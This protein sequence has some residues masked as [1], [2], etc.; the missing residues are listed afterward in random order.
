MISPEAAKRSP[1]TRNAS[2]RDD[3]WQWN[4]STPHDEV[5]CMLVWSVRG[6]QAILTVWTLTCVPSVLERR[7][8]CLHASAKQTVCIWWMHM[9]NVMYNSEVNFILIRLMIM[10]CITWTA[11]PMMASSV[12]LLPWTNTCGQCISKSI[13]QLCFLRIASKVWNFTILINLWMLLACESL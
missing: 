12:L 3:Q 2:R 4:G 6:L 11:W 10:T 5:L 1:T 9:V 13:M 7:R 8:R